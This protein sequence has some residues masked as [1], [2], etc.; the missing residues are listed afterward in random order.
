V[1][2]L[3]PYSKQKYFMSVVYEALRFNVHIG[4]LTAGNVGNLVH[5]IYLKTFQDAAFLTVHFFRN[6]E[7]R[8]GL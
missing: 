1:P 6:S 2:Q 5:V 3:N 8:K 7:S 4:N